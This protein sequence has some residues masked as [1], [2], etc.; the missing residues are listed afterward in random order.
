MKRKPDGITGRVYSDDRTRKE[1]NETSLAVPP[2]MEYAPTIMT[3][4]C[5]SI[6]MSVAVLF[7]VGCSRRAVGISPTQPAGI[8]STTRAGHGAV[9]G[10]ERQRQLL[11]E[12]SSREIMERQREISP[13]APDET[14]LAQMM[15]DVVDAAT[16]N[17]RPRL[18]AMLGSVVPSRDHLSLVLTFEGDRV[19]GPYLTGASAP[20]RQELVARAMGWARMT[21][22][23]VYSATGAEIAQGAP[24]ASRLDRNMQRIGALLRPL[25]RFYRVSLA[26]PGTARS[27]V[28]ET[29]VYAGGRWLFVPEPWRFAPGEP[30]RGTVSP[31]PRWSVHLHAMPPAR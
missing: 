29:F 21:Q 25:V 14:G 18:E 6:S 8:S 19:L 23:S 24:A 4:W 16:R 13:Y 26:E 3:R 31:T 20:S 15:R 17:D 11:E 30:A 27:A 1:G 7:F 12:T 5:F 28:I 2:G 22:V 9:D 10:R